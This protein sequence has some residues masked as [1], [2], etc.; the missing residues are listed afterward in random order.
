[1]L[2]R[3]FIFK[4][5]YVILITIVLTILYLFAKIKKSI[6]SKIFISLTVVIQLTYLIWRFTSTAPYEGSLALTVFLLLLFLEVLE[7]LDNGMT[8]IIFWSP[9]RLKTFSLKGFDQTQTVDILIAVYHESIDI[10]KKTVVCCLNLKFPPNLVTI[11]VCDD[12]RRPEIEELCQVLGVNYITR[13][14]NLHAKAGNLNNAL[15]KT[16]SKFILILDCDMMVK[17]NFLQK[18]LPILKMKKSGSFKHLNH[19]TIMIPF[20][21]ISF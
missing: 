19:F 13:E 16:S 5:E 4:V 12:G 18:T 9:Y 8:K 15:S 17:S 21:T 2:T 6:F 11:S 1:M 20:S 3:L 10:L 14:D 7:F